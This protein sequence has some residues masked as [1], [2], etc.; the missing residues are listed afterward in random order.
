MS[1]WALFH[2]ALSLNWN[3]KSMYDV[4]RLRLF[5]N[6]ESSSLCERKR[7]VT[8][9]FFVHLQRWKLALFPS[10]FGKADKLLFSIAFQSKATVRGKW[11]W[12][13][14]FLSQVRIFVLEKIH[15]NANFFPSFELHLNNSKLIVV[16]IILGYFSRANYRIIA[17]IVNT[18]EWIKIKYND[19]MY[20]WPKSIFIQFESFLNTNR[21]YKVFDQF[22]SIQ[23][24][25]KIK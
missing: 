22:F 25:I 16:H 4:W 14:L 15:L 1:N 6:D 17:E 5:G 10:G 2:Y 23:F 20:A 11:N 24:S 13:K 8:H 7:R 3:N 9:L 18:S 19:R 21:V 12:L